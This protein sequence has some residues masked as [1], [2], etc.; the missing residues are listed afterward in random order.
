MSDP[1]KPI[2]DPSFWRRRLLEAQAKG[3]GL[4][5]SIY[6][7]DPETWQRIEND[8]AGVLKRHLLPGQRVLDAGCGYGALLGLLPTLDPPLRYVGVD[9]SPEMVEIAR[10]RH[11]GGE[12]QVGNLAALPFGNKAFDWAVARSILCMVHDN[13]GSEVAEAV[14]AEV[15]RV[16]KL[17]IWI[18]YGDV[19]GYRVEP[20]GSRGVPLL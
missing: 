1:K 10:L 5:N 4:H 2:N 9:L 13:L 3:E 16:A 20:E 8:T 14:R 12:F 19:L 18:E 17:T 11:P 6:I 7:T 15:L